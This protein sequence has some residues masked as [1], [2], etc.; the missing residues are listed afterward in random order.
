[1]PDLTARGVASTAVQPMITPV[2]AVHW[3]RRDFVAR[4]AKFSLGVSRRDWGLA[5][6]KRVIVM[7][8]AL[9]CWVGSGAANAQE[10][11]RLLLDAY[12]SA[13]PAPETLDQAVRNRPRG[14][15]GVENNAHIEFL[16]PLNFTV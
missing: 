4:A 6:G 12:N 1:M 7:M 9:A 3:P 8:I 10:R 14:R 13:L 11:S 15:L 2:N 5:P 16:D